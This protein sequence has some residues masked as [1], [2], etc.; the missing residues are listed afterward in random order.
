[1]VNDENRS[2]EYDDKGQRV[3]WLKDLDANG[4]ID[5]VE[6]GTY[7]DEGHLV[8][9][10]IDNN[11]DGNVDRIDFRSY[12]DFD[13]LA[14]LAR[15]NKEVGDGNAEQLFFYKNTEISNTDHLS[16]LENIYFQKDNLEVTISDDVLDKIANDDN[17]HKVIVNSKKSG[18]V[19]NLDGNFVKTTDTEAHG[20]QDY[21]KYTDD[22]GNALIVDPDVTVNII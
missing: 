15:D 18:D 4:S 9:L 3:K 2:Y 21:V 1:G 14:S 13:D 20:G 11:N 8:K 7:D 17:S 16:G 5:K 12:D 10:E 6:K 19:L 22:A